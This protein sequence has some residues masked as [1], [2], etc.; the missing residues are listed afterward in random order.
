M[1]TTTI[2][3]G[4]LAAM[5]LVGGCGSDPEAGNDPGQES[6]SV[7]NDTNNGD[8]D[9]LDPPIDVDSTGSADL[10]GLPVGGQVPD[11]DNPFDEIGS[12]RCGQI[13]WVGPDIPDG[14]GVEIIELDTPDEVTVTGGGCPG[15]WPS[16]VG[17]VSF[18]ADIR[19]CELG[20]RLE[21][22]RAD[23]ESPAIGGTARAVC[24]S[25]DLCDQ[26]ASSAGDPPTIS[27]DIPV[28]DDSSGDDGSQ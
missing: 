2:A 18:T 3:W 1:R 9:D 21:S 20:L 6:T 22:T 17:G 15:E 26:F 14:V 25:Q 7:D 11:A 10:P 28:E 5:L 23:D 27:V 4:L 16:C 12:E 19:T 8:G 24:D 13:A